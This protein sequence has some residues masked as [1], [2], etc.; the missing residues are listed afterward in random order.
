MSLPTPAQWTEHRNAEGRTYWYHSATKQSSWERPDELKSP[1]E[2]A[3]SKTTW[4]EYFSQGRKYWY[5]TESKESKWDMPN[6]LMELMEKV[7]KEQASKPPVTSASPVSTVAPTA[8]RPPSFVPGNLIGPASTLP[9]TGSLSSGT[10]LPARPLVNGLPISSNSVLPAKPSAPDDPVIPINGFPTK[11]EAEKA[12]FH[13]LKKA[14]V[15]ATSTWDRTMRAIITDPLYKALPTLAE[16]KAAWE[17]YVA[18]LKQKEKDERDARLN[19]ARPGFKALLSGNPQILYYTTFR[20]AERLFSQHPTWLSLKSVDE[21]R[22]LFDEHTDELKSFEMTRAR[23]TRTRAMQK[24]VAVFKSLKVDVLSRWRDTQRA[25][26]A[27]DMWKED[28]EFRELADLDV[29]LAFE[30]FSRVLERNYDD[31][32][33]RTEMERNT[34]E[35]KARE[36]FRELLGELI[37]SGKIRA[38]TKWKQVYPLFQDDKRYLDLLGNPGSN[39]LELFWDTVD[40][41]DQE[42]ESQAAKVEKVLEANQLQFTID[43]TKEQYLGVVQADAALPN[44]T[45][46]DLERVFDHLH[47]LRA[48]ALAEERRKA[49]RRQ[50]HLQDD[51]RYALKKI[52]AIDI[53]GSY[54]DA[55]P[56]MEQL[57]EFQKLEEEGRRVAF[58]KFVKRQK[59]KLREA[60]DDGNSTSGRRRKE[61]HGEL[62]YGDRDR[63]R[64]SER[65]S[66]HHHRDAMEVEPSDRSP[67]PRDR[68]SAYD[69]RERSRER[70]RERERGRDRDYDRRSYDRRHDKDDG[71]S[72]RG[73]HRE[74]YRDKRRRSR[75]LSSD[76]ADYPV[77][78]GESPYPNPKDVGLKGVDDEPKAKR[79]KMDEQLA[80]PPARDSSPEEGEI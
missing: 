21:R 42:L 50:R 60:S 78:L 27:S 43:M 13:L 36:A 37:S 7:E 54:E 35:R 47:D 38:K 3:L 69:R 24:L 74:E 65:S 2:R 9:I 14:G 53:N 28:I 20:T 8:N 22:H 12:F 79:V 72:S 49:E 70:E 32:H 19:K 4:K 57:E 44:F 10:T 17:K 30:D 75:D 6:E 16:K 61:P 71:R 41:L 52:S 76:R 39:P 34:L 58:A 45:R 67:H 80:A 51:L 23:E 77:P 55:V 63:P 48:K 1:F 62:D 29:L 68:R 56:Y 18:D 31:H 25:V 73:H 11:E 40:A 15:D 64:D 46:E 59:E 33:R 5:N 66:R 26:Y